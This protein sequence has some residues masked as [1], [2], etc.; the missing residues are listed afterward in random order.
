MAEVLI[1]CRW[2]E[3]RTEYFPVG[4]IHGG[5]NLEAIGEQGA[6]LAST[7]DYFRLLSTINGSRS[8]GLLTAILRWTPLIGQSGRES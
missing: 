8:A 7:V 4:A 2:D 1:G 5:C 3:K 6:W